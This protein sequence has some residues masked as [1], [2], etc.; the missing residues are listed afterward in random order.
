MELNS[1][2]ENKMYKKCPI[3]L[4]NFSIHNWLREGLSSSYDMIIDDWTNNISKNAPII[5][6]FLSEG[7][8]GEHD[9]KP[10][11]FGLMVSSMSFNST[12]NTCMLIGQISRAN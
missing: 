5:I 9:A 7:S 1:K 12:W 8:N 11:H 2:F 4:Y 6:I 3:Y 10:S